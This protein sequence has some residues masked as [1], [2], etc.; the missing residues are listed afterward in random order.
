[1]K[2]KLN[3]RFVTI[4]RERTVTKTIWEA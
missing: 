4:G 3:K 2:E 1:L